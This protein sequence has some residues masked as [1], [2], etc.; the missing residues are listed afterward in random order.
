MITYIYFTLNQNYKTIYQK[1]SCD[2]HV[3]LEG[4]STINTL[5][6]K[7]LKK[8]IQLENYEINKSHILN[9]IENSL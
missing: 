1:Y 4:I 3:Q 6:V 9:Q 7:Y 2:R 8:K 5:K